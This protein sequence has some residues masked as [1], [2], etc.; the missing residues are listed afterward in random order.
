MNACVEVLPFEAERATPAELTA[1]YE[2]ST[3]AQV[4]D[5]EH[6]VLLDY[7][8]WVSALSQPA[9][10]LGPRRT[11]VV[12]RDG[13]L[14]ARAVAYFPDNENGHFALTEITVAPR[15]RR[16]GVGK[17][18]LRALLPE[19]ESHGRSVVEGWDLAKDG[20]GHRW[21]IDVGLHTAKS[22]VAQTLKIE[23]VDRSRWDVP[24]PDGYRLVAWAGTAPEELVS[25]YAQALFAMRDAPVEDSD[26]R[27]ADWTAARVREEEA[28][29]QE[30]G[31][32][33]RVVVAIDENTGNAVAV[34]QMDVYETYP[35]WGIQQDTAVVPAHRGHGLGRC[36]KAHMLRLL[37]SERP[38][39]DRV[40]TNVNAGNEHMMRVNDQ[41]GFTTTATT[42]AVSAEI[43]ELR[44]RLG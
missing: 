33:Q 17:A 35:T 31:V 22:T 36:V 29:R 44:A 34:T 1:L 30:Q 9:A 19:L 37:L 11:W 10:G 28:A 26:Y 18:V 4:Q 8:A 25:T 23:N 6:P 12:R 24:V 32:V 16:E 43:A 3:A 7:Q 38:E 14:V 42:V 20:A 40:F 13:E 5:H 39:V 15:R 27:F 41:I 2:L 21:A